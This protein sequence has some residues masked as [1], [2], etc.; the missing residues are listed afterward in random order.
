MNSTLTVERRRREGGG[1]TPCD[2][3]FGRL[4]VRPFVV[5]LEYYLHS[6]STPQEV[7]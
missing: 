3:D 1:R 2:V 6:I 5:F 4:Q 7:M